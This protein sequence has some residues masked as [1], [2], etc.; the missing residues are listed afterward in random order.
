MGNGP[1]ALA[2]Y[3]ELFEELDQWHGGFIWE[4]RDHGLR[5]HAADGTEYFGYGGDFGE[6]VHDGS[7]VCDGLV[8]ADG[9][10][11]PAL[12][13]VAAVFAPVMP[14]PPNTCASAGCS[15]PAPPWSPAATCRSLRWRRDND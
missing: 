8:L 10:A 14:S 2:E 7:F 9:T 11:S 3:E 15:R 6:V 1:G 13:D 4:W 5:T 12:R